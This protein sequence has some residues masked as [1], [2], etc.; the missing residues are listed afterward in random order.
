MFMRSG[1]VMGRT[2]SVGAFLCVRIELR[3]GD[4]RRGAQGGNLRYMSK[5]TAA[6]S[7]EP[8]VETN[9]LVELIS[10]ARG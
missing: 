1:V 6:V 10:T 4:G 8:L 7:T 3:A 5:A 9:P 2:P